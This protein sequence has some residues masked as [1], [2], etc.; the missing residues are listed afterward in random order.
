MHAQERVICRAGSLTCRVATRVRPPS[1]SGRVWLSSGLTA[2]LPQPCL[3][4]TGSIEVPA[5]RFLCEHLRQ[6]DFI[7]ACT[8][9]IH[10]QVPVV[11]TGQLT[12]TFH[13]QIP[14]GIDIPIVPG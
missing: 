10:A 11:T 12:K 1:W 9:R 6:N 5:S 13:Q 8:S 2:L 4:Q 7:W 14:C 3:F